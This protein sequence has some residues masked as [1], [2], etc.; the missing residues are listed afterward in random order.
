MDYRPIGPQSFAAR[1]PPETREYLFNLY[2][3]DIRRLEQ[4]LG[5]DLSHWR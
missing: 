1:M 3:D 2:K 5:C 4:M